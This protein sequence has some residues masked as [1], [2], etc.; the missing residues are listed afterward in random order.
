MKHFYALSYQIQILFTSER[1]FHKQVLVSMFHPPTTS[2]GFSFIIVVGPIFPLPDCMLAP[3]R[4][5]IQEFTFYYMHFLTSNPIEQESTPTDLDH[6]QDDKMISHDGYLPRSA[7]WR[8]YLLRRSLRHRGYGTLSSLGANLNCFSETPW[9]MLLAHT[10]LR[11]R[12][13]SQFAPGSHH[14]VWPQTTHPL[15]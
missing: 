6:L 11:L 2:A 12:F 1:L 4:M 3:P 13:P 10:D 14:L 5:Y 9:S 15:C 7:S 8:R